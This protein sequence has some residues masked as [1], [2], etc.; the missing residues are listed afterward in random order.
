[1]NYKVLK[2]IIVTLKEKFKCPNCMKRYS[3]KEIGV[4]GVREANLLLSCHCRKCSTQTIVDVVLVTDEEINSKRKH[5]GLKVQ[6][7]P[8]QRITQNDVLDI[9]NF[10][11]EFHG[12]FKTLFKN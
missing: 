11:K 10:L 6:A 9:K 3:N 7:K 1:M 8:L 12:D 2:E 4:E 5:Q